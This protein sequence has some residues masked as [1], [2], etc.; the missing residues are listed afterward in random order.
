MKYAIQT[1][2]GFNWEYVGSDDQGNRL[3]FNTRQEAEQDMNGTIN[4]MGYQPDT[5]RVIPYDPETD[6]KSDL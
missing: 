2:F 6:T 4:A 5:W 3:I 1:L